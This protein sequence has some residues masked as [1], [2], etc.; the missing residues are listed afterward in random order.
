MPSRRGRV[1]KVTQYGRSRDDG[2]T[3]SPLSVVL[4]ASAVG[5]LLL[6]EARPRLRRRHHAHRRQALGLDFCQHHRQGPQVSVEP[7]LI[8]NNGA[9]L[10]YQSKD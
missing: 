4:P 6:A 3:P 8:M 9:I 5:A 2:E 7:A 1:R 10:H